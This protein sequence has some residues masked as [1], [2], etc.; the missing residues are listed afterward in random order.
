MKFSNEVFRF[1]LV[2]MN[3]RINGIIYFGVKNKFYGEIVGVKV[4]SKDFFIDYFNVMIKQYFEESEIKVVKKCIRELR[5]VEVLLQ[6]N[7]LFDRFVIEVDVILKYFICKEKYF[8]I[9]M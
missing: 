3:L 1:V 6:N 8:Y 5:F 2:C 9:K 7:I 4:I